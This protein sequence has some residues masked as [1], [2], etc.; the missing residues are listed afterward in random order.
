MLHYTDYLG[1]AIEVPEDGLDSLPEY[2]HVG[3]KFL[4]APAGFFVQSHGRSYK[5]D[6]IQTSWLALPDYTSSTSSTGELSRHAEEILWGD[7]DDNHDEP[8]SDIHEESEA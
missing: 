5:L 7:I 2:S 6:Y 1:E 4:A 3:A 8:S